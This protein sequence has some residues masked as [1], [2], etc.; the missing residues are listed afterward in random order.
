MKREER[1]RHRSAGYLEA[2]E[3]HDEEARR[4]A[5]QDDVDQV[6]AEEGVIPET[7]LQPEGRMDERIVL[8]R[9]AGLEPDPRQA[10]P[11]SQPC[12][13]QVPVIVPEH[14]AVQRRRVH[15]DQRH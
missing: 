4:H 12:P 7:R 6:V 10:V 3:K 15:D 1:T 14:G 2:P 8:L 13:R 5:V 9:R 11:R